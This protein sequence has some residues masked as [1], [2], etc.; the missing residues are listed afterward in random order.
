MRADDYDAMLASWGLARG[1]AV[2]CTCSIC[3]RHF[4]FVLPASS[5]DEPWH[6]GPPTFACPY[7][8]GGGG[9]LGEF[10]PIRIG[11]EGLGAF[12]ITLRCV[13]RTCGLRYAYDG[14]IARCPGCFI[15][16][17]RDVMDSAVARLHEPQD[18][19][20][21]DLEDSLSRLVATFDGV[22]RASLA[23][24][25]K[26]SAWFAQ[27][28]MFPEFLSFQSLDAARINLLPGW[29]MAGGLRAEDWRFLVVLFHKRHLVVHQLGVID[30]KYVAKVDATAK[31][32]S[33][34]PLDIRD[35]QRGGALLQEIVRTFFG[36]WL[37]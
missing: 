7:A 10:S 34:I 3:Q 23:V 22:M 8:C 5:V 19:T 25:A 27:P 20:R 17:L 24:S 16:N 4:A 11:L 18:W 9:D 2:R 26:N 14:V 6:D 37:S 36:W 28:S 13:R 1:D 29:D 21:I 31:L 12:D 35:L 30:A 32:G 33:R 15:E